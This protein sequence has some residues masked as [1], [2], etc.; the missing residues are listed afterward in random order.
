MAV[1]ILVPPRLRVVAGS[2]WAETF[3]FWLDA[4]KTEAD[5]GVNG[6]DAQLTLT[7]LGLPAADPIV[8]TTS[9]VLTTTGGA[10]NVDVSQTA[11]E[12]WTPGEYRL[13]LRVYDPAMDV[14]RHTVI[15]DA[16]SH[17]I[18]HPSPGS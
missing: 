18:V 2:G 8:L 15:S 13:T 6:L 16:L 10:V 5:T 7:R 3:A 1:I 17:M 4:A 12:A 14:D 11:S 9:D